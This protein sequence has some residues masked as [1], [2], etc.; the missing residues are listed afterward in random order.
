[1]KLFLNSLPTSGSLHLVT[2]PPSLSS[3]FVIMHWDMCQL[4]GAEFRGQGQTVPIFARSFEHSL[5][6]L[7]SQCTLLEKL[8]TNVKA[9]V[10]AQGSAV[11]QREGGQRCLC[12]GLHLTPTSAG[13]WMHKSHAFCSRTLLLRA[14][15][16]FWN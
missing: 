5:A 11:G 15:Y 14:Q 1:M 2:P 8:G 9:R 7:V 13:L 12:Q 16:L 6:S 10:I 3:Q 4:N